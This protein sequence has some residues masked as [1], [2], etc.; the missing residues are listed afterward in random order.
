[1]T[2]HTLELPMAQIKELCDRHQI[3]EFALFGSVL[4]DDFRP[5]SD[6]DVLISFAPNARKGLLTLAQIK[7]EL[8]DLLGRNVDILTKKSIQQSH[9]PARSRN[10]L[11]SAQVLYVA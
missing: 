10:I 7:H 11:N 9:N 3:I 2:I 5:N 4:R 1:M 6:I 8:E